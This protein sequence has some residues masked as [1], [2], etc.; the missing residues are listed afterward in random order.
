MK[1]IDRS[2]ALED[3]AQISVQLNRGDLQI[4]GKPGDRIRVRARLHGN[5]QAQLVSDLDQGKL[6]LG[7]P[8]GERGS[9]RPLDLYLT[10]PEGK[11]LP[12]W[13]SLGAGDVR[14][15][16]IDGPVE[17]STGKGDLS[18]V[19]GDGDLTLETGKGDLRV[20]QH[21]GSLQ[22]RTGKGDVSVT[23][24]EGPLAISS[25]LGDVTVRHWR[26]AGAEGRQEPSAETD[27]LIE[28]GAGDAAIQAATAS[29]LTLRTGRGD[30]HLAELDISRLQVTSAK[31]DLILFGNPGTGT[32]EATTRKGDIRVS[33]PDG[34]SARVEAATRRGDI[35]S[36]LPQVRV[37][38]PGPA[39]RQ[40]GGRTIG[41]IGEEP[42]ADIQLETVI[43]DIHVRLAGQAP[44]S[45]PPAE[46]LPSEVVTAMVGE[47][48]DVG[49]VVTPAEEADG[50]T[51]LSILESLARGELS[52][53]EAEILL[54][55]LPA[56][57]TPVPVG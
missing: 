16:R 12:L 53:D 48:D 20:E 40:G 31:G 28:V 11:R 52:V 35:R 1:E 22:A 23:A 6:I 43:G 25:G 46:D 44:A 54:H 15:R 32:W 37:G 50:S 30:C 5:S 7:Q 3:V 10:L 19:G 13:A 41:V 34:I 24:L 39:S 21:R 38:R 27:N 51:T 18:L 9:G 49:S 2:F 14:I 55:S 56:P 42:R 57:L 47:A 4:D 17:I 36:D 33:L 26:Q 8:S 29:Q 45:S